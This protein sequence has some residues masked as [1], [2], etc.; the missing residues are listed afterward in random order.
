MASHKLDFT[1]KSTDRV[2]RLYP[3]NGESSV[4]GLK[5]DVRKALTHDNYT[6][7]DMVNALPCIL[8]QQFKRHHLDCPRLDEYIA[9]REELLTETV[10]HIDYT[11]NALPDEP[12]ENAIIKSEHNKRSPSKKARPREEPVSS[13]HVRR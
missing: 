11:I 8:S 2:G 13:H 3:K 1:L 12:G 9:R 4:Q 7:I 10:G 6:D 5:R